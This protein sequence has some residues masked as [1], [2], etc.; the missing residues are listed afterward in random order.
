[1]GNCTGFAKLFK[2]YKSLC[3]LQYTSLHH[4]ED[5]SIAELKI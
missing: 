1:M 3:I 5:I 2:K 4:D